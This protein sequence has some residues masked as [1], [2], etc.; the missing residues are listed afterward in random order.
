MFPLY[1]KLFRTKQGPSFAHP[2]LQS[3]EILEFLENLVRQGHPCHICPFTFST[4]QPFNF[5]TV[6]PFNH[7]TSPEPSFHLANS[8]GCGYAF[9]QST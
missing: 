9:L 6:Q 7:S 1:G 8:G 5:S 4:F 2:A 3:L